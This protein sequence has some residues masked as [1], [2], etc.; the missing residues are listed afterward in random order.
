VAGSAERVR[1]WLDEFPKDLGKLDL[2][3]L[4]EVL[5]DAEAFNRVPVWRHCVY[6]GCQQT[7]DVAG[8]S[9]NS[10]NG[11]GWFHVRPTILSGYV[12][13]DHAWLVKVHRFTWTRVETVLRGNCACGWESIPARWR[14]VVE[15]SWQEHL[16]NTHE[17][18]E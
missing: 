13:P 17:P 12:C 11:K 14:G 10:A 16:L 3:A 7:F 15:T 8:Q 9:G 4:S 5:S 18:E 2:D 6:P 1:S